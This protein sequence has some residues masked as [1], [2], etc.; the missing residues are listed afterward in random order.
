MTSTLTSSWDIICKIVAI[1]ESQL[2]VTDATLVSSNA[3]Y[4]SSFALTSYNNILLAP[5]T[6]VNTKQNIL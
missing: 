2:L 4:D 5:Y 6:V 1:Q 3:P